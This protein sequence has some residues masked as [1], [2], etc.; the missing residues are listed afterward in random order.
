[1]TLFSLQVGVLCSHVGIRSSVM[2]SMPE[3]VHP[4][5]FRD[6]NDAV[7]GAG[8]TLDLILH[9]S[10]DGEEDPPG[11][12][13]VPVVS[14]PTSAV[15][16]TPSEWEALLFAGLEQKPIFNPLHRLIGLSPGMMTAKKKLQKAAATDHPGLLTGENGTGKDLAATIVHQMSRCSDGPFIAVNCGAIPVTLAE[17]Q[18]FGSVKGAFTDATDSRGFCQE[19]SGGTLFLDE[20]GELPLEIQAK[21]LRVIENRELRRV[22]SLKVESAEFRLVCA[23]NRNLLQAVKTGRFREDLYYRIAVLAV[24]LPALRERSDDIPLLVRHFSKAKLSLG[25]I[26]KLAV[27]TWPGNLRQLK[28]ALIE[29]EVNYGEGTLEA[30]HFDLS[31]V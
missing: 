22:G 8:G 24:K 21:L 29:A 1:M 19:A 9:L 12:F 13:D 2:A 30:K 27:H 5:A 28:N 10:A 4:V 11:L 25:A 23:T 14:L 31:E 7:T 3:T 17:A 6:W 18:L 16:R 20:I 15:G 26:Q